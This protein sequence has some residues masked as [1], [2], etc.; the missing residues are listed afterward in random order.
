MFDRIGYYSAKFVD[1]EVRVHLVNIKHYYDIMN[2]E[3]SQGPK[4]ILENNYI[5]FHMNFCKLES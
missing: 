3:S 2:L 5:K 1:T 4:V